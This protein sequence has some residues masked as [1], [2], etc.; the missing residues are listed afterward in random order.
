VKEVNV[1]FYR[2]E[3]Q[4]YAVMDQLFGRLMKN[5]NATDQ[6]ARSNLVIRLNTRQPNAQILLDGR[7][8]PVE[9]L[10]GPQ[11]GKA[12]LELNLEADTLHKIWLGEVRLR[13]AFFG[14]QIATKGY[15]FKA[16]QLGDLFVEAERQYPQVL[17]E[18]GLR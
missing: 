3:K 1:A 11:A 12:D 16:M 10:F 8:R 18:M 15:V 17:T 7:G 13:D 2:D 14:G 9:A 5:S 6:F 4:F